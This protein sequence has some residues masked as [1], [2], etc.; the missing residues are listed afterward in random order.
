MAG[1]ALE[2]A[3]RDG[4][5]LHAERHGTGR[6]VVVLEAGMGT[7]RSSWGAVVPLVAERTT[8]VAYD[9]AG[10]GRSPPDP[11][12][13]DLD[14]L[15]A[16]LLD[17]LAAL[18]EGPFVLVGHSWGGPIVRCAA[19][20]RPEL[21]AG[22]VL[23][24]PS[25]EGCDLFFSAGSRRQQAMLPWVLPPLA[26]LGVLRAAAR[27]QARSLPE[28]W[29]GAMRAEDGTVAATRTL[30]AESRRWLDDLRRLRDEPP[31]L[32]DVPVVVISGATA[33]FLERGRR[34][35]LVAAHRARAAASP[36]GRHVLAHRSSHLVPLTEPE[37][38]A[39]E[40]LAV[41]DGR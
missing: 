3:T 6:P 40:V 23:V 1:K 28:P 25:D 39:R 7:S 36:R 30:L 4:R 38:V 11:G 5:R 31:H 14:R 33:G 34:G 10:L 19:A 18:G 2:V 29:A 20:A 8:V 35:P 32:P 21:V 22:L 37:V 16:D 15:A 17:L 13:R 12:P 27:R 24:D 41:V 26:R 9:R